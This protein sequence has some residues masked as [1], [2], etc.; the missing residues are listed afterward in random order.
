MSSDKYNPSTD[1]F[2]L[3][4]Y[5][6]EAD[7]HARTLTDGIL[8][9]ERS[10]DALQ[11]AE[12]LMRA[13]H[14][15]K[16]AARMVGFDVVVEL[17]HAMEDCFVAAQKGSI[18]LN[19][20]HI[21]VLLKTVDLISDLSE[22]RTENINDDV[23]ISIKHSI[24]SIASG[25]FTPPQQSNENS[26]M[27]EADGTMLELFK[28]D[29]LSLYSNIIATIDSISSSSPNKDEI[30]AIQRS[31]HMMS[32]GAKLAGQSIL[33]EF[34]SAI[35][36][37]LISHIENDID[38]SVE[39]FEELQNLL[40]TLH[41]WI[42]NGA[43]NDLSAVT[44]TIN[45]I[46]P[47]NNVQ[48]GTKP[49]ENPTPSSATQSTEISSK[50]IDSSI[51][52]STRR[53]NRL[54]GLASENVV[55][56]RWVRS[57]ADAMLVYKR[58]QTELV[59]ALDS[60]RNY[61]DEA[62]VPEHINEIFNEV[63][64][65]AN[66][67]RAYL[68]S[69]LTELDDFDRRI[70]GLSERLNHEVIQT[71]MRPFADC[72]HGFE[73]MIRDISRKLGKQVQLNIDGGNTQVDREIL[74]RIEAPLNHIL[75]NAVDHGIESK[76][77]RSQLNKPETATI[78]LSAAHNMGML[79]INIT[80]DGKGVDI[81]S[82]RNRIVER[83]LVSAEMAANLNDNELLDFLYLPGFST[84]SDVTE[85]SGRGVGLDVVHNTIQEM[86]GQIRT[87]STAG[88][89]MRIQLMLPLTLS[90]IRSLL[91]KIGGQPY[92]I[93]LARI[94][95]IHT[96]ARNEI[97]TIDGKQFFHLNDRHIGLVDASQVLEAGVSDISKDDFSI[98]VLGDRHTRYGLVVDKFI[99]ERD[100]AVHIL[101][102]RLG[103]IR[104]IS[105]ATLLD[106]GCPALII[107]V[108]D[109][110]RS[111]ELLISG[112]RLNKIERPDSEEP[113]I[114]KKTILV[115]DDSITVREVEKK[116]LVS[117]G[118]SVDVAVDGMD[119]WNTVQ[120][121][122]YD[123]IISDIDMPRMNGIEFV[124]MLKSSDTYKA[125]PVMIVSY[126]DRQEDRDAGLQAG[127]DYYLT[128]GS[129]HDESL[130]DA[131]IDLIGEP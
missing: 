49:E 80:D 66:D 77:E 73:R 13:A 43:D 124:T 22:G 12:P 75:R 11:A 24:G 99:G 50:P 42:L 57:H 1:P 81:D 108:D 33:A 25:S 53:M 79:S 8:N 10:D 120:N 127:A 112:E 9:L 126:K 72:T 68:S 113:T 82:L 16:G 128:K 56:S 17:A 67:S 95:S 125:L 28:A 41:D 27:P 103:K 105:A 116:L 23:I 29:A 62:G 85:I 94:D 104:D 63:Q 129:F 45:K 74:N 87:F 109:I 131:V 102:P 92:A 52:I 61:L 83:K 91:V 122:N 32:G 78:T 106:N 4:L 44:D 36:N 15:I 123:L 21:D 2:M 117:R 111:I 35:D 93:P 71:R 96:L 115:V 114:K 7:T 100:L 60:L 118:Y 88:E 31:I 55:E 5:R 65:R 69:R 110:I 84:R 39:A 46:K 51:R 26:S 97:E 37:I 98:V 48:T 107:D 89:G 58:R 54:V 59:G 38:L 76:D 101:D 34:C 18:I 3:D 6:Q 86:R 90:V 19:E 40:L 70:T 20:S 119:G 14:S 130:I 121:S 30:S 47:V 64:R